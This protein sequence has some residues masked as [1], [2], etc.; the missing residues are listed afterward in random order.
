MQNV[1]RDVVADTCWG[2]LFLRPSAGRGGGEVGRAAL[3]PC[4]LWLAFVVPLTLADILPNTALF[5]L[6]LMPSA[7]FTLKPR[8]WRYSYI[9]SPIG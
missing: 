7:I 1:S 2:L 8:T 5:S 3:T 4:S 9:D 6:G